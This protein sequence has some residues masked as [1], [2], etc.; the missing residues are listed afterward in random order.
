MIAI[1]TAV[2]TMSP[3]LRD[4][5]KALPTGS[6]RLEIVA[7]FTT[8]ELLADR[9]KAILPDMVL[10]E[11]AQGETDRIARTILAAVPRGRVIAFSGGAR[12]AYIHE[13]RPHRTALSN[14]SAKTVIRAISS[15]HR[16]GRSS[17]VP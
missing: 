1:R 12:H 10:I 13:M 15:C 7:E 5:I 2:V 16:P 8:R 4:M 17:S 9:L 11:L 14:V 6:V 3:M